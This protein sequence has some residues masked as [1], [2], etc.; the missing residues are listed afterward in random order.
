MV[1]SSL[2]YQMTTLI[3]IGRAAKEELSS[4]ICPFVSGPHGILISS[5]GTTALTEDTSL[6]L[7]QFD[8]NYLSKA[9]SSSL[10]ERLIPSI[11]FPS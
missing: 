5:L 9:I 11:F 8:P 6:F 3:E 7:I 2:S 4:F 10:I 1:N